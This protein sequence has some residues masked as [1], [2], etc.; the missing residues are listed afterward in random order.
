[1]VPDEEKTNSRNAGSAPDRPSRQSALGLP[2]DRGSNHVSLKEERPRFI[3]DCMLGRLARW[4]RILGLDA[5]YFRKIHGQEL[6]SLH[7]DSGR[8]LLTR[9]TGLIQCH[10]IG[11]Y[12]FIQNDR[13]EAQLREVLQAFSLTISRDKVLT[14]C[15]QCNAPLK[16]LDTGEVI[17]KVPDFVASIH[18]EFR[19][20]ET[21]GQIYWSGTHGQHIAKVLTRLGMEAP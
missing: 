7:R 6:L 15:L 20:C 10:D 19:G 3:I 2:P 12:L 18:T 8:I 14:R 13:W 11:P 21:C 4:L 16:R 17:G 9:D 5:W 1:M